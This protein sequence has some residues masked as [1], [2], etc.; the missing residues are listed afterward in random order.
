MLA[1]PLCGRCCGTYE[2]ACK[3]KAG[4]RKKAERVF[5]IRPTSIET[6]DRQSTTLIG[7]RHRP[8]V[9]NAA[10][11]ACRS[12]FN[13]NTVCVELLN[14]IFV[15]AVIKRLNRKLPRL[16]STCFRLAQLKQFAVSYLEVPVEYENLQVEI[17][18]SDL[19]RSVPR[20]Q[21]GTTA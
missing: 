4:R 15:P 2:A 13:L 20:E 17:L 3:F 19:G 6:C 18:Y 1:A 16:C 8:D 10:N 7:N 5:N 14:A 9:S 12:C 11:A 21:M